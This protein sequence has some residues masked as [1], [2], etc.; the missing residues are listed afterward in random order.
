M[1]DL[2]A[3]GWAES[4]GAGKTDAW[5]LKLDANGN[6]SGYQEGLIEK[7]R[8]TWFHPIL[9][10]FKLTE[11]HHSGRGVPLRVIPP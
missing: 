8:K 11:T 4:Y 10:F 2:L 9:P 3:A 7:E 6:I 5:A 1:E